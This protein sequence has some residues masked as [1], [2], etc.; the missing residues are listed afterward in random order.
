MAINDLDSIHT[1]S[2]LL[3][4]DSI[5]GRFPGSIHVVDDHT[6][7]LG[8]ES[9]L[10]SVK[11]YNNPDPSTIPWGEEGVDIVFECSGRFTTR[12][13]AAAHLK[14]GAKRVLVS[15]P[16]DN[17]DITVVFGVNHQLL[18]NNHQIISNASC[19]TNC[20]A[21]VAMILDDA[22]GITMGYMTTIHAYTGDQRLV[23]TLHK[24]LRRARSAPLSM[25][26]STTGAAKMVGLVLPQ[27]KGKLDGSAIRV[28][29]PNVSLID[30]TFCSDNFL[31]AQSINDV[32]QAKADKGALKGVLMIAPP[33]LVSCDFNHTSASAHIDLDQTQVCQN[34]LGRILAWYDNEWG[35]SN[36]MLDV[37]EYIDHHLIQEKLTDEGNKNG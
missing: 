13:K 28:P 7:S 31:T 26:P 21:P 3:Q 4:Y 8:G 5:H 10:G 1:Q 6:I 35:F 2:H 14:G 15:S 16:C 23:D 12:D 30:F 37:A 29:V 22:F 18:S 9:G 27:L 17:A 34:H 32:L 25:I 36:R 11:V 24:D 19:T 20:L 33:H